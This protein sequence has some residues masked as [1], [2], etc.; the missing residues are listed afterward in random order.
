MCNELT[1]QELLTQWVEIDEH[2]KELWIAYL[3]AGK[4]QFNERDKEALRTI[5][6]ASKQAQ[7][8]YRR[9]ID[10]TLRE[11]GLPPKRNN[12]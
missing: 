8:A 3:K 1:A 2:Y 7:E 9:Y 4:W 12:E 11:I 6:E 5:D 10:A